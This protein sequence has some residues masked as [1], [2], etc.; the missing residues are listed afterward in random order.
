M[1]IFQTTN[2]LFAEHTAERMYLAVLHKTLGVKEIE[3]TYADESTGVIACEGSDPYI[4][5]K[6]LKTPEEDST[7]RW[8]D[9]NLDPIWNVEL[10][11]AHPKVP[12]DIKKAWMYNP[13]CFVLVEPKTNLMTGESQ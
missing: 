2:E 11:D 13:Y 7:K 9:G 1:I 10:V 3:V 8:I 5:V 4:M 12:N 6:I